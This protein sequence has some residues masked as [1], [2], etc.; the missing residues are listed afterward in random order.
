[1]SRLVITGHSSRW[2]DY[3]YTKNGSRWQYGRAH[4]KD[5]ATH[6]TREVPAWI[7]RHGTRQL[8]AVKP[9]ELEAAIGPE[10]GL[11]TVLKGNG[12]RLK[13]NYRR[14]P[15]T[16]PLPLWDLAAVLDR[17]DHLGIRLH[18]NDNNTGR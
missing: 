5:Q 1:M 12:S 17:A 3:R 4:I 16:G 10:A 8:Y 15:A 7:G 13:F 11:N 18:L 6:Q 14:V 2:N 9:Y